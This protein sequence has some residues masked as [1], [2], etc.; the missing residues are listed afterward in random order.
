MPEEVDAD[1]TYE[2]TL[3]VSAENAEDASAPVTV[4]VLNKPSLTLV[5]TPP[6]PVYEGAADFDLN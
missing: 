2:Y 6:A 5:C 3:T 4:R 1:D